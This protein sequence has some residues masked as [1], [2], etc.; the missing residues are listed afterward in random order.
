MSEKI[1]Q[2][3]E[4]VIKGQIKELVRGSVEEA[5]NELL[6]KE[7]ES[8][9]Q[10]ARYERSEAR[11]GYR[12]GHYDRSLTTTSGDVTLHIPR[13][14]GVSFETAII[15]R[16]RRRESSVEEALIK[17]YLAGVS[18]RRV[19]DI[20]EALWG[21]K[22]SPATISELNKK[23]YLHIEDWR[24]RPLQGGCYPY[25]YVDGI[26]LRRNWGGEYENVSVLV[27]IAVNEDGF[28]EVLGA[29]EGMKEDKAS[30]V[31]FFQWLRGRGLDGVKLIVG[32]K[33]K[34]MLEAVGEVFPDAKYQRCTV[35][36]YR[37]VFSV[38][39]KSKV[40]IVAKML[41]AIHAQESKKASREKAKAVVAELRAMKLKEAAKKVE[42]GIEETLTYRTSGCVEQSIVLYEYQ[43]TKKAEHAET[44]LRGFNGWLHADGYQGYHKLPGNIRVVGCWAH[45]RRK[46]DEALQ[47]LPKEMQKDSPAAIGECYCSRLFKLEQTFAE[48]APEERYEKRLEQAKPVLDALLS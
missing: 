35:H 24:N 1:V 43:P 19:E 2:L 39:P 14:K 7:A 29:A 47:T 28:R 40:K 42:D 21:S 27:A 8:L 13:L 38:V 20:T 37:N 18:V 44:F 26:Y 15:E 48:L 9:T 3:N 11:Q 32:D 36:F 23:A 22:V 46:F 30:W 6:E 33:C 5:L 12:S 16:Y 34:G 17:M 41:K 4:E 25:V 31:S 45:A 10:A